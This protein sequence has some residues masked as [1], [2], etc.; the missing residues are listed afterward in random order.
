MLGTTEYTEHTDE[1]KTLSKPADARG[2]AP[3]REIIRFERW[4]DMIFVVGP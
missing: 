4:A 3:S 2:K 1:G